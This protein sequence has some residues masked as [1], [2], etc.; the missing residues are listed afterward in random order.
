M[1]LTDRRRA[2]E[3]ECAEVINPTADPLAIAA[4][5]G[6]AAADRLVAGDLAAGDIGTGAAVNVYAAAEPVATVRA[7]CRSRRRPRWT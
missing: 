6:T 7:R 4:A 3:G 1:V 5:A 2:I